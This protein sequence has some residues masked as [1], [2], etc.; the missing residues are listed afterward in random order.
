MNHVFFNYLEIELLYFG[1]IQLLYRKFV[2]RFIFMKKIIMKYFRDITF[3]E[4]FIENHMK[5]VLLKF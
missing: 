2:C 4:V 3:C 1:F 5:E